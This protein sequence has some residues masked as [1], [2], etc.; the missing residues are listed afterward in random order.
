MPPQCSVQEE[1]LEQS[2]EPP[3]AES[4]QESAE[5]EDGVPDKAATQSLAP[6]QLMPV[7]ATATVQSCSPDTSLQDESLV[8][9]PSSRKAAFKAKEE[10]QRM[11][12]ILNRRPK[13]A[14][15]SRKKEVSSTYILC[16]LMILIFLSSEINWHQLKNE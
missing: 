9:R 4:I 1:A 15:L 13:M 7:D 6:V 10:I 11:A 5:E 14:R 2:P 3:T 16:F 12:A 8:R